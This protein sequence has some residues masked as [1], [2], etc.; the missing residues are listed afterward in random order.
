MA[1]PETG[2]LSG[3]SGGVEFLPLR[4]EAGHG[5]PAARVAGRGAEAGA[6]IEVVLGG[7]RVLRIPPGFD[8]QTLGEVLAVLEAR[9][10]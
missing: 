2:R 1:R 10:C 3:V 8:R 6:A 5:A 4:I 7:Q 9:P